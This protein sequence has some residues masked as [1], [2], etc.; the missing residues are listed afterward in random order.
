M[1]NLK[2]MQ[3]KEKKIGRNLCLQFNVKLKTI[4][5]KL[6]IMKKSQNKKILERIKSKIKKMTS[7]KIKNDMNIIKSIK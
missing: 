5:I 7:K 3:V 6:K 1:I 2:Q 4:K